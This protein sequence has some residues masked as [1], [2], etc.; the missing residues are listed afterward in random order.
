MAGN[1]KG[2]IVEIG[3]D[4]SGLQ[5]ALSQVNKATGSLS[6]E[7]SSINRLLKLDPSNTTLVAQKQQ[8]LKESIEATSQK[9]EQL[10]NIQDEYV[11]NGGDLNSEN[12]RALQRE[13]E[14]TQRK[15]S[16][17]K[18]EASNWNKVGNELE[19]IGKKFQEID[20]SMN[21]LGNK[22]T[23]RLS[24]P[25]AAFTGLGITYNAQIETY[26]KSFENFLGDAK[27]AEKTINSIKNSAAKSP[28]D[29]ASLIRANQ[30][31]I[32]TGEN[33][34]DAQSTILALGDAITATGGGNDELT[35]MASNLQQVKNAGKATAMDIRQFAY[36]GIDVYGLLADYTGKTTQEVKDMEVSYEDLSGALKKA[37]SQ[38]GKY[39]NA[40]TSASQTLTGQTNQLKAEVKDMVGDL[41]KSLMPT[42]KK[43]VARAKELVQGFDRLSDSQKENIVRIGLLVA[44]AG[45]LLKIGGTAI[46]TIGK[47]V[48]ATGTLTKAIG[49]MKNGIGDATGPAA[50]LAKS[51]QSI[52]PAAGLAVAGAGALAIAYGVYS[53]KM[54]EVTKAER[55]QN[56]AIK[57]SVEATKEKLQSYQ[58][59]R[60]S[61]DRNMNS[62]V[63]E[64]NYNKSLFS[65][66]KT[67]VDENGKI[68]EGY[69]ARAKYITGQLSDAFG[70]EIDVNGDIIESYQKIQE[71][72]DNTLLKQ[73]AYEKYQNSQEK[74]EQA[75]KNQE[76]VTVELNQTTTEL[77]KMRKEYERLTAT[78][79]T[80]LVA[81]IAGVG[82][83]IATLGKSKGELK[84]LQNNIAQLEEKERRLNAELNRYS[85]LT[86]EATRDS[87]LW[88][89]GTKESLEELANS[90]SAYVEI[91]GELVKK[92]SKQNIEA[93]E[94]N[95]QIEK[96]KLE[97]SI[98][99][100]DEANQRIIQGKIDNYNRQ[101]EEQANALLEMTSI[102]ERNTPDVVEAWRQMAQNE[103]DIYGQILANCGPEQKRAIQAMVDATGEY[104]PKL[105]YA[106]MD[107]MIKT[108]A[109]M[110]QSSSFRD[111]A[112][113]DMQGFLNGLNDT[114]LREVLQY[115]G[116]QDVESVMKGIREGNLAKAEGQKIL[117]SLAQGLN[118]GTLT[119]SLFKTARGLSS[120]LSSL[121]SVKA[122]VSTGTIP[123]H[124]SGLDYVPYD[125]YIARLH[126]GERVL[127]AEENKKLIELQ[128]GSSAAIN[129][130][131]KNSSSAVFTTPNIVFNVQKMDE[132][133]LQACFNYINR[134]FG[135]AY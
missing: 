118:D 86:T 50:N 90:T 21:N 30:M 24:A 19:L 114:Q 33:A 100:N 78:D 71:E 102:T 77:E 75:R 83:N 56:Q 58:E 116:I 28:F 66:L 35:R 107:M 93:L 87:E 79:S 51:L 31:L 131:L 60:D 120:R 23:T 13:I 92:T 65:E 22:L 54:N 72:I 135:S 18:N 3:G 39:Y 1:I 105:Q 89:S 123:G 125:N 42:A 27:E 67:I 130:S 110:H 133:N 95:I 46:G 111:A 9:L 53:E 48:G 57:D 104:S 38:G 61:L 47:I 73:Q 122:T 32:A 82:K 55:E 59:E 37:S 7:L 41:T 76:S 113:D 5:K 84:N 11:K 127:T 115:A 45:P 91:N 25:I 64:I 129:S 14:T 94:T 74:A 99:N 68:K 112:L 2:I 44:A 96:E 29:T 8:V 132:A 52:D 101:L 62:K 117:T 40:M 63:A 98:K 10:K 81:G 109:K 103:S 20:S 85:D 88:A 70:I 121:L 126:K 49:L 80:K 12:Y 106:S 36:A 43:I 134:K 26:T 15:L 69:E 97:E 128:K 108:V 4:T 124:K 6:R 34:D 119:N 16:N 17:F